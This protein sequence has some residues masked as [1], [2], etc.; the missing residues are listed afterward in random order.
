[1]LKYFSLQSD[2]TSVYRSGKRFLIDSE[3]LVVGDVIDLYEGDNVPADCRIVEIKGEHKL[4]FN[5]T[6]LAGILDDNAPPIITN[7]S[8]N[9]EYND[10]NSIDVSSIAKAANICW[11][12]STV[13]KGSCKAIV[14]NVGLN[15]L[16]SRLITSNRWVEKK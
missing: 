7:A 13:H 14:I 3:N 16:W 1:M 6:V 4:Q 15:T 8:V 9:Y 10:D 5:T 11:V 2:S 12:G